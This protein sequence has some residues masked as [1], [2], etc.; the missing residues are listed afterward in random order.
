MLDRV[1]EY[2]EAGVRVVWLIDPENSKAVVYRSLTDVREV[3]LDEYL[4]GGDVLP[5]FRC[6]LREIL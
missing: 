4:E 1:G 3:G 6:L 5:G 2:L